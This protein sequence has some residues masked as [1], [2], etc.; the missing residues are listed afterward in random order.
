M[1]VST[2]EVNKEYATVLLGE[3]VR[4]KKESYQVFPS[5]IIKHI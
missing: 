1:L 4:K 3:L 5:S 2:V